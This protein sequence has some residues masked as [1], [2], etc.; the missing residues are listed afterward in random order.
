MKLNPSETK[1]IEALRN[2]ANLNAK[3]QGELD[4]LEAKLNDNSTSHEVINPAP[5]AQVVGIAEMKLRDNDPDKPVMIRL[6]ESVGGTDIL[7]LSVKQAD[8]LAASINIYAKGVDAWRQMKTLVGNRR[9]EVEL[10]VQLQKKGSSYVD[11]NGVIVIRDTDGA[12]VLPQ[13]IILP[14][15]IQQDMDTQAV[16]TVVKSWT[17]SARFLPQP[18]GVSVGADE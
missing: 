3:E 16:K 11:R 1:R 2:K 15:S 8:S 10:S 17:S 18:Q 6:V 12:S 5:T 14:M 4:S 7:L 9:S 13:T